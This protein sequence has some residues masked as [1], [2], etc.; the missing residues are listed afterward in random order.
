MKNAKDKSGQAVI[1]LWFSPAASP[2]VKR[3]ESLK[4]LRHLLTPS[5]TRGSWNPNCPPLLL[6][7]KHSTPLPTFPYIWVPVGRKALRADDIPDKGDKKGDILI[8]MSFLWPL[9]FPE[10]LISGAEKNFRDTIISQ[11][12]FSPYLEHVQ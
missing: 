2:Q 10:S 11:V 9:A 5:E 12:V 4:R 3:T 6:G 7:Q 8:G 1:M